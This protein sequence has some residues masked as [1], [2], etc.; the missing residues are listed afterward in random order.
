MGIFLEDEVKQI[1]EGEATYSLREAWKTIYGTYP[2]NKSLA[3]LWSQWAL[4]T[5]RGKAIHC[6]NFGNLKR[7]SDDSTDWTMFRCSEILNGKE[8][9]FDPPHPQ[10]HF[11]AYHTAIDGAADYILFL[12][13]RK[14]YAKAWVQVQKGDAAAFSHELKVAGYYTANEARY[15]EMVVKLTT[16]FLGK[17]NKLLEWRPPVVI[18]PPDKTAAELADV[19]IIVPD[20]RSGPE[21]QDPEP[22][23]VP[24]N[25]LM[26]LVDALLKL[27]LR[28]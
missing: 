25:W 24:K 19:P 23:D 5:G 3:L 16:E 15:T 26:L 18:S 22:L 27:F 13:K 7:S 12:S 17:V 11:R 1:G 21:E 9:F 10:T 20:L 2:S 14:R 8:V 28:K 6:Y 4:E